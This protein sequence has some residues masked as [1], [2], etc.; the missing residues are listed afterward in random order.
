MLGFAR[1]EGKG[2]EEKGRSSRT[3]WMLV[4]GEVP[5]KDLAKVGAA[6]PVVPWAVARRGRGRR[7][8]GGERDYG[9]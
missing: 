5:G 4:A 8:P 7:A 9:N 1:Q 2:R 3:L 6:R